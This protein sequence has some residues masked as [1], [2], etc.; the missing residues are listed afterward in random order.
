MSGSDGRPS[1]LFLTQALPHPL[2]DGGNIRSYHVLRAL[3]RRYAV[4]LAGT[5][6]EPVEMARPEHPLRRLAVP[7]AKDGSPRFYGRAL[8]EALRGRPAQIAYN[9]SPALAA[10][11]RGRLGRPFDV[12]HLNHAD[13]AQY[14]TPPAGRRTSA[15]M[16]ANSCPPT[17]VNVAQYLSVRHGTLSGSRVIT[18]AAAW[19]PSWRRSPSSPRATSTTRFASGSESYI[20]LSSVAIL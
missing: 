16:R 1:L 17:P 2:S 18:T 8:F 5:T 12:V 14:A 13:A 6:R 3:S 4:T 9:F 11:L 19:I 10:E 20:A 7:E 15:S